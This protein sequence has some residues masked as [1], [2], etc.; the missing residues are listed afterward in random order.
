MNL[1]K[2]KKLAEIAWVSGDFHLKGN[3]SDYS[4][5]ENGFIAAMEIQKRRLEALQKLSELDEEFGLI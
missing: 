3:D 1:D 5:F 4:H 2:L